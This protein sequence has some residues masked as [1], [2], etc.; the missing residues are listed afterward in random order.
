[1]DSDG[2]VLDFGQKRGAAADR[3]QRQRDEDERQ[4]QQCPDVIWHGGRLD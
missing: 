2:L 4:R 1:M 3:Q